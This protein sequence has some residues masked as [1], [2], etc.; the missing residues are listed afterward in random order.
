MKNTFFFGEY[1]STIG[2][3]TFKETDTFRIVLKEFFSG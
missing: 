1:E 2:K 3:D